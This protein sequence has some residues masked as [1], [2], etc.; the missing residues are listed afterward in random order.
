MKAAIASGLTPVAIVHHIDGS[1]EVRL[2]EEPYD[3][4]RN[5]WKPTGKSWNI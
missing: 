1:V 3:P 2:S 4:R 5:G